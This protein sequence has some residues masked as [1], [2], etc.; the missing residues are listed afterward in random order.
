MKILIVFLFF[1]STVV[2][3]NKPLEIKIDS[4]QTQDLTTSE[5]KYTLHFHIKNKTSKDISFFLNHKSIIPNA[6]SSMSIRPI[7]KLY[8]NNVFID[9]DGVFE[10]YIE[11]EPIDKKNLELQ[12]SQYKIFKDSIVSIY[13][14]NGG[15][16]T[17]EDWVLRNHFISKSIVTL[18]P[19]EIKYYQVS[20]YWSRKRYFFNDP[21][22]YYL[23]END[24]YEMELYLHL[25]KEELQDQLTK[26]EWENIKANPNFM[27]GIV[28]SNKISID[29][30]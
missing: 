6:V 11:E 9:V 13:T 22:E 20:I 24:T 27:K 14:K 12:M 10:K 23:N 3:Q 28:T 19:N 1:I 18:L 8:Q 16:S 25:L 5:R 30:K 2:S 15:E 17:N 21:F 26:K 4:I 29:F 7:Y